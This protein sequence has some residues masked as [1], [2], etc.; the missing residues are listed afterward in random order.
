VIPCFDQ[1]DEHLHECL[2]SVRE[3]TFADWEVIV[4]DDGSTRATWWA[5]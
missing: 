3:Q 2:E 4:V 1:P 5:S